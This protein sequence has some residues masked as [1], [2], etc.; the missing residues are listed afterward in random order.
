MKSPPSVWWWNTHFKCKV[1][2]HLITCLE[3]LLFKFENGICKKKF[4]IGIKHDTCGSIWHE[5]FYLTRV[6]LSD[7]CG[8]ICDT[9]GS[10]WHVWF[11]LTRV[12][13]S[14]VWSSLTTLVYNFQTATCIILTFLIE[15]KQGSYLIM[16]HCHGF[17]K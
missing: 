8:S 10:I 7:T 9:C 2:K 4:Q 1:V 11:Y 16:I 5:W 13:L 12:V 6:V 14:E 17:P 3:I 15:E